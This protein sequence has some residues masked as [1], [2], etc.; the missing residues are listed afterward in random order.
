MC[1]RWA[2]N[3]PQYLC[4]FSNTVFVPCTPCILSRH[5]SPCVYCA[6]VDCK[7]QLNAQ[8]LFFLGVT[9]YQSVTAPHS[10][11]AHLFDT[12][13]EALIFLLRYDT[14]S[15]I[16]VYAYNKESN[17]I[18]T[19]L[20]APLVEV[21]TTP[22]GVMKYEL[23]VDDTNNCISITNVASRSMTFEYKIM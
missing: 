17:Q 9:K 7:K 3:P 23:Y 19:I 16:G 4:R 20:A 8:L 14:G 15:R 10:G 21:V 2:Y 18:E 5:T 22:S 13:T 11:T 6:F 1:K 12:P